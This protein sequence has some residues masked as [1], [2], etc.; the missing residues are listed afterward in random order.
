MA[1]PQVDQYAGQFTNTAITLDAASPL[2][3]IHPG[4]RFLRLQ[5]QDYSGLLRAHLISVHI[6]PIAFHCIV[7]NNILPDLDP[8]GNRFLIPDWTSLRF[9]PSSPYATAAMIVDEPVF[10]H[11]H[12]SIS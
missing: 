5:W 4:L 8:T 6:P 7:D 12:I 11:D 10:V 2:R 9:L 3:T 1:S